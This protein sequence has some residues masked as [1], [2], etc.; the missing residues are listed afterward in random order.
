ML[1]D[2]KEVSKDSRRFATR[3]LRLYAVV[4]VVVIHLGLGYLLVDS[5]LTQHYFAEA[6]FLI[7]GFWGSVVVAAVTVVVICVDKLLARHYSRKLA[8]DVK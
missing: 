4:F 5:M 3:F 1:I 8:G 6:L 7:V 2:T